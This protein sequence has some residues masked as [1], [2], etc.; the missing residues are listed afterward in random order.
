[1]LVV[2]RL[3]EALR[4][5]NPAKKLRS[6]VADLAAE[7]QSKASIYDALEEVLI[8][9]R[10][11]GNKRDAEEEVVL[12]VTDALSDWCHPSARLLP[13]SPPISGSNP[14]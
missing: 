2:S 6:L 5:E 13:D 9:L 3:V 1:M 10:E 14:R 8:H 12:D 4:S 7:G 11:D